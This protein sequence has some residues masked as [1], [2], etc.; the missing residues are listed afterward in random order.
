MDKE[1]HLRHIRSVLEAGG[2][3]LV[4]KQHCKTFLGAAHALRVSQT[5]AAYRLNNSGKTAAAFIE[6]KCGIYSR[7]LVTTCNGRK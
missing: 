7:N 1:I 2:V 3:S 5:Q 6:D 4:K